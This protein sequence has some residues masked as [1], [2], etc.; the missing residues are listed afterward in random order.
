[1]E[2]SRPPRPPRA[3]RSPRGPAPP[4]RVGG[5]RVGGPRL[6]GIRPAALPARGEADWYRRSVFYEVLT[7]GFFDANDD[8]LGDLAGLRAKLDYL[9]WLGVDCLWLLPYYPSPMRDGGYDISDFFTVHPH[10]GTLDDLVAFLD[11]AHRRDIRVI[12]DLVMN[13]TSDE[14]PW[15]VE[16]SSSRTNPK[17]DWY[18]WN[19][20]DQRWPESR[21][22]FV[23]VETSNWTWKVERQQYY[24][25]RFYSHQP[26]L[27]FENPEVVEAMFRV[28]RFWLDLGLDGFRLDAVPYLFQRDGTTGENL[29][30]THQLLRQ[31]RKEID[32][33]Y[34]DRVLLAEANQWPADLV[35][36]FG[37]A[38]ECHMCFHF[39]LMPRLF[40]AVRREQRFPVTEILAQTPEI[41]ASCQWAIFL[42]NH[43]E[44][45]LE[46][47]TEEERDYMVAEYVRDPRMRRHMGIGRRLAPLLDGDRRLAELL[48]ALLFSLPGS[49]VLYYGDELLMGDNVYLGDRDS[50]RT[51]MQWS[52]DRNGGFSRADF[53]QLYLPPLMDPV[54][55]FSAVNVEAQQRSPSSFLHWTR[56]MIQTRKQ[57]PV[58]GTGRF[59]V[60]ACANPSILA[61]V[62]SPVEMVGSDE[63]APPPRRGR[64]SRRHAGAALVESPVLCVHNLSRFTQPAALDLVRWAGRLPAE[65]LGRVPFPPI[66]QQNYA[67]TLG[68]YGFYWFELLEPP[69][70]DGGQPAT[71]EGGRL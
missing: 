45:T 68:P 70:A 44:L 46:K 35:D 18:V 11:D 49:P 52:P 16:S 55:G 58:F 61:Y 5:Q 14:H 32:A 3:R 47:V 20:D 9:E 2:V 37:D 8:G 69:P 65:L 64:H 51:P 1:M 54:Y 6:P 31:L 12:A 59:E 38:D 25:H 34:P 15:F 13:H 53:A 41:P 48:N 36:Y 17:A 60:V 19:D 33:A 22:V 24:W 7:R 56:S 67:V 21:V 29:P 4:R 27:N 28:M 23:D 10:L 39:P 50:V 26:D 43:D 40:M 71:E 42:R 63:E 57:F 66:G 30:E 62:R